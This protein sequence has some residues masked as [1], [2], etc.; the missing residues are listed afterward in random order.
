MTEK[1]VRLAAP[2]R[3]SARYY[4]AIRFAACF[5]QISELNTLGST[6]AASKLIPVKQWNEWAH[7]SVAL[8]NPSKQDA[9]S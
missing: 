2:D 6:N 5:N 1:L 8:Q 3:Q 4:Q 7:N 9:A